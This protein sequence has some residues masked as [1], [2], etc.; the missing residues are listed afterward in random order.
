MTKQIDTKKEAA[1]LALIEAETLTAAAEAAGISR[2]TLYNYIHNDREFYDAYKK[3]KQAQL[4]ESIE[5]AQAAENMAMDYIIGLVK[6]TE[7]PV[8]QRLSAACKIL[9]L[10]KNYRTAEAQLDKDV[11][12]G[13]QRSNVCESLYD[14]DWSEALESYIKTLPPVP[15]DNE[16]DCA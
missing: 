11:K 8:Q 5:K 2:K 10:A 1:L 16:E 14:L 12:P 4:R 3:I 15:D 7:T 6:D 13:N 9:D